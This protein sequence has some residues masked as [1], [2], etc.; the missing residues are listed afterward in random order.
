M[1][2]VILKY[3]YYYYITSCDNGYEELNVDQKSSQIDA[4]K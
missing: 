4:S 3:Y 1:K 2:K